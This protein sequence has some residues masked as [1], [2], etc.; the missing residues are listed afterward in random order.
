MATDPLV[1]DGLD[2]F[3][4]DSHVLHD[5]SLRV[6][7]GGVLGLL[8][9]NG[10]GKSTCIGSIVG[11]VR[12]KAREMTLYGEPIQGLSPERISQKGV[13]VVPQGRRIFPSLTV[14][15]NLTVAARTPS[16]EG[17]RGW[18]LE[19]AFSAF[20]RLEERRRQFAGS[21]SGGEQQ[22]LAIGR[23]LMTGPRLLLLDEPSEGLAP[24][25][26]AEVARV[27]KE[28]SRTGLSIVL[29]EQ[30]VKLAMEVADDVVILNNG[31][32]AHAGPVESIQTDGELVEQL[33]GV[34]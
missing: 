11:L 9:R 5:L 16:R 19:D 24:Q 12:A 8:G 10:A 21:L 29:V 7:A 4:G 28:L 2:A 15:E 1:L 17:W 27:L 33:L 25:I 13:G 23:A 14:H 31:R 20:P 34:Y 3:Y 6:R 30:N 26:V 32:V 18:S 22:M